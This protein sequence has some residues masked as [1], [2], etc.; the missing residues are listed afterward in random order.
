MRLNIFFTLGH[1]PYPFT[2]LGTWTVLLF[3]WFIQLFYFPTCALQQLR[4]YKSISFIFLS[5]TKS[6]RVYIMNLNNIHLKPVTFILNLGFI[7]KYV[8]PD[9]DQVKDCIVIY[10]CTVELMFILELLKSFH[11]WIHHMP[12]ILGCFVKSVHFCIHVLIIMMYL[13]FFLDGFR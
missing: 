3:I 5:E 7:E 2:F 11:G 4:M 9:V 12:C 8:G 10:D 13:S 6:Y 1:L